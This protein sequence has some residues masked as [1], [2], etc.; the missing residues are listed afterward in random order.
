MKIKHVLL[1][2]FVSNLIR[3]YLQMTKIVHRTEFLQNY[4]QN[5]QIGKS[6]F[7]RELIPLRYYET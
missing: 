7:P 6:Q 4:S 3:F 2:K 1:R 5:R